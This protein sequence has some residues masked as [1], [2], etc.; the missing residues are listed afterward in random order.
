MTTHDD[1]RSSRDQVCVASV[2]PGTLS[3]AI[4][5]GLPVPRGPAH[6]LAHVDQVTRDDLR[7]IGTGSGRPGRRGP[8]GSRPARLR[9]VFDSARS[10]IL[11]RVGSQELSGKGVVTWISVH[12]PRQKKQPGRQQLEG[13]S[14]REPILFAGRMRASREHYL[15]DRSSPRSQFTYLPSY[16]SLWILTRRIRR[17]TV[18]IVVQPSPW[19]IT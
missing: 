7:R 6:P 10:S 12:L 11:A 3:T 18:R 17:S 4:R 15:Q 16:Y 5:S 19:A 2:V 14:C 13:G 8:Q 1:R 9:G